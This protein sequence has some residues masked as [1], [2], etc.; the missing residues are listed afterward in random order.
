MTY[1]EMDVYMYRRYVHTALT[2]L[3]IDSEIFHGIASLHSSRVSLH[4][5]RVS[6]YGLGVSL[7]SSRVNMQRSR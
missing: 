1:V 7:N 5:S 2:G 4:G 6:L 3:R